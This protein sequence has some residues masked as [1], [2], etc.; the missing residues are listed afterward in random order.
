M[1]ALHDSAAT[2]NWFST[3]MGPEATKALSSG[4]GAETGA[5]GAARATRGRRGHSR[6]I[7]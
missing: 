6:C 7:A 4:G 1:T 5:E 3:T 2:S